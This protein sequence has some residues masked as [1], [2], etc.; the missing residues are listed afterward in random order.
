MTAKKTNVLIIED[1]RAIRS[2]IQNA[3]ESEGYGAIAA[4]NGAS[5]LTQLRT[6]RPEIILLDLGLPDVDGIQMVDEIRKDSTHPIIVVS[7]R[8]EDADKIDAL[9]HG[10]DD[11]VTKPFN[12]EELMA[13]VR[14]A[15]RRIEF[16]REAE[17]GA[18]IFKNGAL[19]VNYDSMEAT[20]AGEKVHLT[21][22]EFKL[23]ALLSQHA[24]KVLTHGMIISEIW[25]RN[26]MDEIPTLR[27]FMTTLRKKIESRNGGR[28]L[29]QTH[30]GVGY[31]MVQETEEE[32]R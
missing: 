10:A 8:C 23:L 20:V 27:V 3:L 12:L 2:L 22:I 6:E 9:N 4:Y 18:R 29:I 19:C 24:G 25:G 16:H 17:G 28:K 14:A 31:K 30:I 15:A 26:D 21:P 7:A 11:Y 1:D 32:L 13:R 5:A